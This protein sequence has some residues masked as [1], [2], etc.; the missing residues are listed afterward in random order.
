MQP[1]ALTCHPLTILN[2]SLT[3]AEQSADNQYQILPIFGK[4][5][6]MQPQKQHKHEQN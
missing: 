1:L 6:A 2:K 5:V 4:E 3:L